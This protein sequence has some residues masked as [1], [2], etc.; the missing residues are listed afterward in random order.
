[1]NAIADHWR[2]TPPIT[3]SIFLLTFILSLG[4]YLDLFTKLKLYFNWK[5]IWHNMEWW[6]LF[7]SLFFKGELSPHTLFDFYICF[8]YMYSLETTSFRNKPADFIT[9]IFLGCCLFLVASYMLGLQN[10]S[11]SV[12]TMML[13]LWSRK[14]PNIELSFLDVFHF[15]SC[16]LPYFLFLMT[17]L[18]GNDVTLDLMGILAGHIYYFCEDVVPRVPETRS[19]KVLQAPRWLKRL[20][21]FL[22]VHDFGANDFFGDGGGGFF[23]GW[24]GGEDP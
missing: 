24:L 15:R 18:F 20:C 7:T 11:G 5:L 1:M 2:G 13:Y 23:G 8:R 9:F 6:R 19:K 4:C 16:F 21:D 14:N 22:R 3:R 12:S 10:T 17:L